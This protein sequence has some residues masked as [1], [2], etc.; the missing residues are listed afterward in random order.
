MDGFWSCSLVHP[1]PTVNSCSTSRPAKNARPAH[2]K[3]KP[4]EVVKPE[5]DPA[6]QAALEAIGQQIAEAN[7]KRD[8]LQET[9]RA[10]EGVKKTAAAQLASAAR[11]AQLLQH[12]T[13]AHQTLL[14]TLENDCKVLGIDAS[15]LVTVVVDQSLIT[16]ANA[17][18]AKVLGEEDAKIAAANADRE[19]LKEAIDALTEQLD[20]PNSAYQKCTEAVRAWTE[21]RAELVGDARARQSF[22]G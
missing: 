6:Q 14:R 7:T 10:S 13:S 12:F 15:R 11:V 3:L 5:A 21:R 16:A 8:A 1:Q 2:D 9:I 20:A 4:T 17:A 19:A 22:L 18:A